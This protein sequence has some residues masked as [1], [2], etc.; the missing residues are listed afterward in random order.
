MR[1]GK[2]RDPCE[3]CTHMLAA[4]RRGDV[5]LC[6]KCSDRAAEARGKNYPDGMDWGRGR[7]VQGGH[8]GSGK[9]R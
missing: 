3:D 9:R 5:R 4:D 7:E 8:P 1:R 6:Q 2:R